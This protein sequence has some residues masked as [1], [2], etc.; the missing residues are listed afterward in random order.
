MLRVSGDLKNLDLITCVVQ[1]GKGETVWA[2]ARAAGA[3][4]ATIF[5]G[6]GMGVRER[7]GLLGVAIAP[8]KEVVTVVSFPKATDRIYQ[9]MIKA[10]K[11]DVAG[12][13]II[14]VQRI[15]R[16]AGLVVATR[17]KKRK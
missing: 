8:E 9:A 14:F 13:G 12:Q 1:R 15:D 10:G 5:F 11:L 16:C 2:A 6:R 7:L 3:G 4:G 17:K